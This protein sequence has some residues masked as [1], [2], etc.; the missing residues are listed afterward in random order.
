MD[1]RLKCRH[2]AELIPPEQ[3][4]EHLR[5][6]VPGADALDLTAVTDHFTLTGGRRVMGEGEY[7]CLVLMREDLLS[8]AM[9]RAFT[10]EEVASLTDDDMRWLARRVG[11]GCMEDFWLVLELVAEGMID[12]RLKRPPRND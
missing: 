7:A 10:P 3:D 9:N 12:K 6:H 2:C 5:R 4:R 8:D 11:E 1:I